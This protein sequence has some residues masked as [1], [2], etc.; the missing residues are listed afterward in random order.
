MPQ[1]SVTELKNKLEGPPNTSGLLERLFVL[2][3]D[4]GDVWNAKVTNLQWFLQLLAF[5][6]SYLRILRLE[7]ET[8]MMRPET[9][10]EFMNEKSMLHSRKV[11]LMQGRFCGVVD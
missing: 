10:N 4:E 3:A 7:G 11:I 1:V 2:L 6:A 8:E 9:R 5:L